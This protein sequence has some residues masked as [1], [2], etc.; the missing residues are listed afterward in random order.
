MK[1]KSWILLL[2]AAL[3]LCACSSNGLPIPTAASRSGET[4]PDKPKGETAPSGVPL[5]S[6]AAETEQTQAPETA[7]VQTEPES[8]AAEP[9]EPETGSGGEPFVTP[10]FYTG[11]TYSVGRF[12]YAEEEGSNYVMD[13]EGHLLDAEKIPSP[14]YDELTGEVR[15]YDRTEYTKIGENYEDVKVST[16]LYDKDGT[17]L[18]EDMPFLFTRACGNCVVRLDSQAA[19]MWEGQFSDY[20]GDL[21]DPY[22]HQVVQKDVCDVIRMTE[23]SA[24]AKDAKG[25]LMGVIDEAGKVLTGFPMETGPYKW[26]SVYGNGFVIAETEDGADGGIVQVLLN[27]DLEYVDHTDEGEQYGTFNC[28]KRGTVL[29]KILSDGTTWLMDMDKWEVILT[30]DDMVRDADEQR[31]IC[32][33]DGAKMLY[34]WSGKKLAGPCEDLCPVR[35]ESGKPWQGLISREGNIVCLRDLDGKILN[36]IELPGL[37]Y[38]SVYSGIVYCSLMEYDIGTGNYNYGTKIYDYQL[39][40]LIPDGY[41]NISAVAP[42]VYACP[43]TTPQGESRQDLFNSAGEMIFSGATSV[44]YG[45]E[46]AIPVVK[47]FSVGLIDLQGNWIAKNSKYTQ[48]TDD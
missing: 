44:G 8:T 17:V 37:S 19:L 22:A 15:F 13:E 7:P 5:S 21:Y 43:V 18:E 42:G 9:T 20:S 47:G 30:T 41:D 26:P 23:D 35:E 36:K 33:E 28:G 34:D 24:L 45:D 3:V 12:W 2:A 39:K 31:I 29:E 14:I 1:I 27:R 32:G 48:E 38:I 25:F 11:K 10:D 46:H 16:T 6:K 4:L 40:Q